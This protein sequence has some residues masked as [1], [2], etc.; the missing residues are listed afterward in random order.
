MAESR[1][2]QAKLCGANVVINPMS[3]DILE[4]VHE[5]VGMAGVDVAFDAC[6]LQATLDT[7]F[8]C[9]KPGGTIFNVA[10]HETS[11][12]VNLNLLTLSEKRLLAGNAYQA[13]D[14]RNVIRLLER[15]SDQ[16]EQLITAIVPLD[17]AVT[18]GFE[19]LVSNRAVHNKILIVANNETSVMSS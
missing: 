15:S 12:T 1:T 2:A 18:G 19:E 14:F 13:E 11:K 17:K 6:G 4:T 16:V 10:I 5:H 7:A 9:T 8:A 3:M